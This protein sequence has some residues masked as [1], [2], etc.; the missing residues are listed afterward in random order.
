MDVVNQDYSV[1]HYEWLNVVHGNN[2]GS[3]GVYSLQMHGDLCNY[4]VTYTVQ[5]Y[6]I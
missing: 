6:S 3:V 4:T 5:I 1:P 2:S